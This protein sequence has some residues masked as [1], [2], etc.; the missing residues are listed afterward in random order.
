[1]AKKAALIAQPRT[2]HKPPP[3]QKQ[4]PFSSRHEGHQQQTQQERRKGP[5]SARASPG[6]PPISLEQLQIASATAEN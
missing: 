1:M 6:R 2:S 4:T 3:T 5:N